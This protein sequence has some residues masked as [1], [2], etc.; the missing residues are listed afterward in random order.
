MFDFSHVCTGGH[1][2]GDLPD[3]YEDACRKSEIII[4]VDSEEVRKL[5]LE[6]GGLRY[7]KRKK[8]NGLVIQKNVPTLGLRKWDRLDPNCSLPD[9]AHVYDKALPFVC[10]FWRCHRDKKGRSWTG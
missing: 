3:T 4:N 5:V 9:T 7:D 8:G 10:S 1:G 2:W 6:E